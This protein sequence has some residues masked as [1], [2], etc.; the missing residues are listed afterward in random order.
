MSEGR[1]DESPREP[2]RYPPPTSPTPPAQWQPPVADPTQW[3]P[4]P[5]VEQG[6]PPQGWYQPPYPDQSPLPA[7]PLAGWW[8]RVGASLLDSMI[9][10]IPLAV[11]VVVLFVVTGASE[12]FGSETDDDL[13]VAFLIGLGLL[14]LIW[15]VVALLYPG[16]TMGR[17]GDRNGQTLGKQLLGIRVV[18]DDAQPVSFGFAL[19]RELVIKGLLIGQIG[20][21]LL[22]IPILLNY[23]WPLWDQSNQAL[24][25]KLIK[26]HVIA[27]A[28]SVSAGAY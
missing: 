22:Y 21:L 12:A 27:A 1:P 28:P 3:P 24:H 2:E 18:R 19:L 13:P 4:P 14:F 9:V 26:T 16:M 15:F 6:P 8:A 10:L 5:P 7:A 25:D 11:A 17:K 20:G 23:L